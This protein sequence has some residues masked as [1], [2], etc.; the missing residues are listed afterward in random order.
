MYSSNAHGSGHVQLN[1]H[2]SRYQSIL[3]TNA[4]PNPSQRHGLPPIGTATVMTHAPSHLTTPAMRIAV[5]DAEY[6]LAPSADGGI[7]RPGRIA[8]WRNSESKPTVKLISFRIPKHRPAQEIK[9][10]WNELHS[11]SA[12]RSSVRASLA[13]AQP[14]PP[15]GLASAPLVLNSLPAAPLFVTIE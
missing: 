8:N 11:G 5:R 7:P 1:P 6:I 3:A 2:R 12:M 14:P 9:V 10:T 4:G 13:P 15:A